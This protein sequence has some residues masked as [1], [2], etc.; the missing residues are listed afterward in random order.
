MAD[1]LKPPPES[2]REALGPQPFGAVGDAIAK[3]LLGADPEHSSMFYRVLRTLAGSP[4]E[5]PAFQPAEVV[6]PGRGFLQQ[7]LPARMLQY[8]DRRPEKIYVGASNQWPANETV[9]YTSRLPAASGFGGSMNPWTRE[10]RTLYPDASTSIMFHPESPFMH[11]APQATAIHEALHAMYRLKTG[12]AS[13]FPPRETWV[14][15]AESA[16]ARGSMAPSR[17]GQLIEGA[18]SEAAIEAL[19]A[20]ILSRTPGQA[21]AQVMSDFMAFAPDVLGSEAIAQTLRAIQNTGQRSLL[22]PSP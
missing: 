5:A 17:F 21:P 1:E 22:R 12:H 20:N 10:A 18:P 15:I 4:V 11:A 16:L 14:P 3:M 9:A 8:L 13:G 2:T 19:T 6:G 7:N